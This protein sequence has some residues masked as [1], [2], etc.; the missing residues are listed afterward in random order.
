MF[1]SMKNL[2]YNCSY[3]LFNF[4][5]IYILFNFIICYR[6][7]SLKGR[8]GYA[9]VNLVD[10]LREGAHV[11]LKHSAPLYSRSKLFSIFISASE[12]Y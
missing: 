6:L 1:L 2:H 10:Q 9:V 8:N 5:A 11:V 12:F 3:T 4:S 7:G